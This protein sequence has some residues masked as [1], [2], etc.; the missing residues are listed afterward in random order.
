M[1]ESPDARALVG[2]SQ[3]AVA[4]GYL[5]DALGFA[6]EALALEPDNPEARLLSDAIKMRYE[7]AA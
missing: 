6:A 2:L 1:G 7:Q 3:V 4:R 5:E